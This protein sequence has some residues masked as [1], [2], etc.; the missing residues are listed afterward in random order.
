MSTLALSQTVRTS[1]VVESKTRTLCAN[2]LVTGAVYDQLKES[3]RNFRRADFLPDQLMA[4]TNS[5]RRAPSQ[6]FAGDSGMWL[7]ESL[8]AC[9]TAEEQESKSATRA[10]YEA[11]VGLYADGKYEEAELGFK[12]VLS[13]DPMDAGAKAFLQRV[14]DHQHSPAPPTTS[15]STMTTPAESPLQPRKVVL[16]PENSTVFGADDEAREDSRQ[17]S[18]TESGV[19]FRSRTAS[20][21]TMV[22]VFEEDTMLP[23]VS[24]GL[25]PPSCN[26][27]VK[28]LEE[29]TMLPPPPVPGS[30]RLNTLIPTPNLHAEYH[31]DLT[32][33]SLH[34]A[35][36][37]AQVKLV[38]VESVTSEDVVKPLVKFE[39]SPGKASVSF[40]VAN[41]DVDDDPAAE[42][43]GDDV[44]PPTPSGAPP[45]VQLP[46][47]QSSTL[48][49]K[50]KLW[51]ML[52]LMLAGPFVGLVVVS[53]L[54][55]TR[56]S[57]A[58]YDNKS[59]V[60]LSGLIT[61]VKHFSRSVQ[62]ERAATVGYLMSGGV[63][64]TGLQQT[65]E[66][67]NR[68]FVAFEDYASQQVELPLPL[69]VRVAI[70]QDIMTQREHLEVCLCQGRIEC[71]D[72]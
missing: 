40:K 19:S 1:N 46:K 4:S 36:K 47:P 31:V 2:F 28:G 43:S 32:S 51:C 30:L 18:S 11:A 26:T 49:V 3:S 37:M 16:F 22:K 48:H 57:H 71:V 13:A 72:K 7:Y 45:K 53:C 35:P 64:S 70:C 69:V 33:I 50:V 54:V 5:F 44:E 55:L 27:L 39:T 21:N 12:K 68:E 63:N 62:A 29:D 38:E 66:A 24:Y 34:Q 10:D 58:L 15:N 9:W 65:R 14:E 42:A 6:H 60:V 52:V 59:A 67:V 25:R 20:R 56:Q 23:G 61:K 8:S 17:S 41:G